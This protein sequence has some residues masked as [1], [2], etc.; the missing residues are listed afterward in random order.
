MIIWLLWIL[1]ASELM[2]AVC[3]W[4]GYVRWCAMRGGRLSLAPVTERP[5]DGAAPSVAVV[6]ACHNEE[7]GIEGFVRSLQLQNYPNLR[8]IVANDRSDDRTGE[9]LRTLAAQD[10]RIQIVEVNHLPNG[11]IG[12]T[13]AVSR[14]VANCEAEYLLFTD[15]DVTLRPHAVATVM[16]KM[17]RDKLDF[18]SLWPHLELRS[19]AEKLLT[20]PVM[21]LLSLSALPRN[22]KAD[23]AARTVLGNGQFMLFRRSAYE[24]LGGHESVAGELA[25]DAVLAAKAH[26]AG[27]RCWSGLGTGLYVTY[28][29][30][31]FA[32][33]SHALAR[34]LI[35]SLRTRRRLLTA[36]QIMLGGVFAPVWMAPAALI[37]LSL[38]LAPSLCIAIVAFCVLHAAG[39]ALTLY[40]AF[41]VTLARRGPLVWFPFGALI[42]AGILFW[43]AFLLS[44]H[45]RVRW[46]STHYRLNGSCVAAAGTE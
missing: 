42:V 45:G 9:I 15:S 27:R 11:W 14:A 24:A 34:V 29:E 32:R 26:A 36:T 37:G 1:A 12:K 28:R 31:G 10:D 21:M 13:H 17:V 41:D 44:G 3:W 30:G 19:F 8:L 2:V 6:V 35:G 39:M 7:Q 25:E 22:P 16:D 43:C 38:G 18:L 5:D 40:D 46:G 4:Y 20:P 33:T 23:V